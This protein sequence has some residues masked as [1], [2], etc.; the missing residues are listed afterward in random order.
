MKAPKYEIGQTVWTINS[1]K[2]IQVKKLEIQAIIIT[3]KTV[4]Y[5]PNSAFFADAYEE[6]AC[7]PTKEA[8]LTHVG[9]SANEA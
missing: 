8:L 3:A 5:C 6:A 4:H 2:T 1:D 7:F 9:Q